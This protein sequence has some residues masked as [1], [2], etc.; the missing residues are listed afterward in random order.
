MLLRLWAHAWDNGL[1]QQLYEVWGPPVE[2]HFRATVG[3]GGLLHTPSRVLVVPWAYADPGRL[4]S[5]PD[6]RLLRLA[7]QESDAA[8]QQ[9]AGTCVEQTGK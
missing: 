2:V 3:R 9:E 5:Q 8:R 1:L 4:Q 7:F 6:L